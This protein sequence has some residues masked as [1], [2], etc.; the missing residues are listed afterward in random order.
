MTFTTILG[1]LLILFAIYSLAA[2]SGLF[3]ERSG[4]I[5]LSI[6]GAMIMGAVGYVAASKLLV[7]SIGH[8]EW[9]VPIIALMVSVVLSIMITSL[10]SFAA[11]NLKGNQVIIGTAINVLAPIISL[12]ILILVSKGQQILPT[13]DYQMITVFVVDFGIPAWGI[14]AIIASIVMVIMG[15]MFYIMKFTTFGLRLRAAGENPHALAAAGVSVVKIKHLAMLLSGVMAGL[16]G[17]IAVSSFIKFSSYNSSIFGMGFIALAILI[18]GQWRMHWI[19][20]GAFIFSGI[21][22]VANSYAF[23]L[24]DNRWYLY[25]IPYVAILITLPLFSMRSAAPKAA[26]IP[27]ENTGR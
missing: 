9:Y 7:D 14:Q 3:A 19:I 17:G 23:K 18:L 15:L 6:N 21:Y 27:Y 16:A 20:L 10:L 25:M 8:L 26:G 1:G 4:T 11:I 5:N 24:A 13:T 12:V 2:S 22:I